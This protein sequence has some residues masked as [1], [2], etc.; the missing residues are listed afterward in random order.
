MATKI[1]IVDTVTALD[2]AGNIVDAMPVREVEGPTANEIG[3]MVDPVLVEIDDEFGAPV[4]YVDGLVA[5]DSAGRRVGVTAVSGGVPSGY[6][7]LL[8]RNASG[9]Y[10]PL[11]YKN[12]TGTY[13]PLA[14]L[15]A[16]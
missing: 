15:K 14:Y 12:A 11:L 8:Y 5:T 6:S 2:S 7:T 3:K 16:A 10:Q 9:D 4:R 13:L 1:R